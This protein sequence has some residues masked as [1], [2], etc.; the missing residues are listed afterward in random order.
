ML[1]CP[2]KNCNSIK[3]NQFRQKTGEIWCM[4]CGLRINKKEL[5]NPFIIDE[6]KT[7]P[8]LHIGR[9][10]SDVFPEKNQGTPDEGEL[11]GILNKNE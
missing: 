7:L 3:I 8:I 5:Y 1:R 2:N 11:Q 10:D 9:T 6:I 4:D